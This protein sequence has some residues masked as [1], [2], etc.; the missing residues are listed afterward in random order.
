MK[1]GRKIGARNHVTMAPVN[2]ETE[3]ER[4]GE[5]GERRNEAVNQE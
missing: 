5:G 4:K 1:R 3:V 2:V